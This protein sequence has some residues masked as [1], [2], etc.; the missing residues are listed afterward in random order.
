MCDDNDIP[1]DVQREPYDFKPLEDYFR[2]I[3]ERKV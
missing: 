3:N 1:Y 2:R